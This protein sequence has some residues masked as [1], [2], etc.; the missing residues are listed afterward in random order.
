MSQGEETSLELR[1]MIVRMKCEKKSFAEI[2]KKSRSTV[3]TIY[4]NYVMRVNV[5]NKYRC[6]RPRKLNDRDAG[7]IVRKVKKNPKTP[8]L[9]N[10]IAA[11][12][13]KKVHPETV[14]RIL[15]SAGYNVRVSRRKP[16]ISSTNKQKRLDFASAHI[17]Q[18]FNFWK[19]VV[20]YRRE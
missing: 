15:R 3:Q 12:T 6:G 13:G 1:N 18:D 10:Q 4:R 2:V 9:A 19:T 11:A 7:T 5:L 14:C 16:F 20:F 17:D 8:K